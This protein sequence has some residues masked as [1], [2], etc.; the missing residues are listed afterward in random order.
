MCPCML[1]A[2]N[3][4]VC[5]WVNV[6]IDIMFFC[7]N[8]ILIQMYLCPCLHVTRL[9][10]PPSYNNVRHVFFEMVWCYLMMLHLWM[11]TLIT[12]LS[13]WLYLIA[14]IS[15]CI[16]MLY[17]TIT[18]SLTFLMWWYVGINMSTGW[19]SICP[20]YNKVWFLDLPSESC[21]NYF[22]S[23]LSLIFAFAFITCHISSLSHISVFSLCACAF[24]RHISGFVICC[25]VFLFWF[26]IIVLITFMKMCEMINKFI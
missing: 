1:L 13:L 16:A 20:N 6:C 24:I 23:V 12:Y 18:C 8:I 5:Y 3:S 17:A 2:T 26:C 14:Y 10:H 4:L 11:F 7:A 25:T 15:Y 21:Y 19:V 9:L 22:L